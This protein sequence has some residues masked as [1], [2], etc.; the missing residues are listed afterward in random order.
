M[1]QIT[2]W[3]T[4]AG[5]FSAFG[6]TQKITDSWTNPEANFKDPY[7]SIFIIVLSQSESVFLYL[8]NMSNIMF[9]MKLKY[10]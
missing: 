6:A 4:K 3:Q 5:T 2:A 7:K 8:Q 10:S 1:V 9:V